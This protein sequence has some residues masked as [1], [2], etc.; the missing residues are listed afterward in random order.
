MGYTLNFIDIWLKLLEYNYDTRRVAYI[1]A[2]KE[3]FKQ[4]YLTKIKV[5]SPKQKVQKLMIKIGGGWYLE[6][7]ARRIPPL[8]ITT[9][10]KKS[11]DKEY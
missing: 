9:L 5:L 2:M 7:S 4:I 1:T 6:K 11:Q 8:K 10:S 3:M